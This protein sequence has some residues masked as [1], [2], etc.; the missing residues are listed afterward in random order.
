M[1]HP[2][3][4]ESA[5]QALISSATPGW[6]LKHSSTCSISSAALAEVEHYAAA[7]PDEP[8]GVLVVQ[9][10]RPLSNWLAGQL[11]YA[12]QSPQ[13]FLVQGGAVKWQASHWGI[14]EE[15]MAKAR[16]ALPAS[17]A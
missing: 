5:A 3:A 2:L 10:Q 17:R 11:K 9:S 6:I 16:A 15:A 13:L 1:K 14:T 12:H 7:H 4:D 8:L